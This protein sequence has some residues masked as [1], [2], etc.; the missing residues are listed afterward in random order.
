MLLLEVFFRSCFNR[1]LSIYF[2]YFSFFK[3]FPALSPN[4]TDEHG[5]TE[6]HEPRTAADQAKIQLAG[7]AVTLIIAIAGG[8]LT[9]NS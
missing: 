4:V 9:G 2:D 5:H 8:I 1:T 6:F 3:I 7:I